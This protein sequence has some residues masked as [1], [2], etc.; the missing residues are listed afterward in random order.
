MNK[1][2]LALVLGAG[3]SMPYGFPSGRQLLMRVCKDLRTGS[4]IRQ[5]L[6]SLSFDAATVENFANALDNSMQQS[7]DA[8]IQ[9]RPEFMDVG[10]AA[11]AAG[12]I[13]YEHVE[14]L[15]RKD[16][17]TWYEYLYSTL[18]TPRPE[19]FPARPLTIIT[20]NYDRSLEQFLIASL[21]NTYGLHP[22]KAAE[23]LKQKISILHMYGQLGELPFPK[24][25]AARKYDG[26]DLS[27]EAVKLA[28][29]QIFVLHERNAAK[30]GELAE[31]RLEWAKVICFL[32]FAF[33]PENV[34]RLGTDRIHNDKAIYASGFELLEGQR[35]HIRTQLLGSF[36]TFQ[37]AEPGDDALTTLQRYGI[38]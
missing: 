20:F 24:S 4:P 2:K 6:A 30:Q 22:V 7:I 14:R 28:A 29:S 10:K 32:G 38:L 17:A 34:R 33:H 37:W 11:I 15:G 13:P 8:F 9:C 21:A 36:K 25:P 16:Q 27:W 23:L 18:V 26:N 31:Q 35:R 3:A 19:D 12:L 1:E 5:A